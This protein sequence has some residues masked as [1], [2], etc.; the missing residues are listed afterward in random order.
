[1][2]PVARVC[3][4]VSADVRRWINYQEGTITVNGLVIKENDLISIDGSTETL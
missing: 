3:K 4:A 2:P 1:M